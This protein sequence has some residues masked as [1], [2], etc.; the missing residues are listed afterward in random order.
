MDLLSHIGTVV[1]RSSFYITKPVGGPADQRD[2]MNAAVTLS[3]IVSPQL[4]L[5]QIKE[6]EKSVG[7]TRTD[8]WGPRII[9][10]DIVMF[11]DVVLNTPTLT[12]PH[13]LMHTRKFVLKPLADVAAYAIHPVYKLQVAELLARVGGDRK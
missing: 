8:K 4:L 6:I 7:R 10:I 1:A 2:Y 12:I 5:Q 3:T 11:G 13:P 9:D